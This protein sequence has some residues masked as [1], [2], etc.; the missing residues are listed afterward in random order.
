MSDNHANAIRTEVNSDFLTAL[1]AC[2]EWRDGSLLFDP[3]SFLNLG[4]SLRAP[5]FAQDG[6]LEVEF[7]TRPKQSGGTRLELVL[8]LFSSVRL[9]MLAQ[10]LAKIVL[11]IPRSISAL[12]LNLDHPHFD[13][14]DLWQERKTNWIRHKL[15]EGKSVILAD[16]RDYFSSIKLSDIENCLRDSGVLSKDVEVTI[17]K[18]DEI[19]GTKDQNGFTRFGIPIAQ[20]TIFWLLADLMLQPVDEKLSQ[21]P[22]IE[23]FIRWVDDFFIA[24]EPHAEGYALEAL[25]TSLSPLGLELNLKKT[26]TMTSIVEY[27]RHMMTFDHRTLDSLMMISTHGELSS[28]NHNAISKLVESKKEDSIEHSR[29]WKRI[30]TLAT[31]LR[32]R[33]LVNSAFT[34]LNLYPMIEKQ[35][36][37]YLHTV[38]WHQGT[39]DLAIKQLSRAP[40]D[41]QSITIL[42]ALLLVALSNHRLDISPLRSFST[43]RHAAL[44]PYSRVLLEACLLFNSARNNSS[45][46]RQLFLLSHESPSPMA[47][48]LAAKL[49]RIERGNLEHSRGHAVRHDDASYMSI[50]EGEDGSG[51]AS[52]FQWRRSGRIDNPEPASSSFN[53]S[54]RAAILPYVASAR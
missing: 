52:E 43:S 41:S 21:D 9:H 48:R 11:P 46:S 32:S 51:N 36:L 29:L 31:K 47:R 38:G 49:H 22:N 33:R 40:T 6:P 17:Q 2:R 4:D 44:H 39:I 3:F 34:D 5:R 25:N 42:K 27:D 14:Y 28:S 26:Q 53:S 54:I 8:D 50:Y 24:V 1:S 18:I 15:V 7:V 13:S 45:V 30:Y 12:A 37:M 10:R 19:N 16:V 23:S 35:V 20:D